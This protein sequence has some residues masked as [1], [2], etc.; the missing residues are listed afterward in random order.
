[1]PDNNHKPTPENTPAPLPSD[2]HL[3]RDWDAIRD[4]FFVPKPLTQDPLVD[5]S[6]TANNFWGPRRILTNQPKE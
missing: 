6:A 5:W 1:M 3:G 4:Y 2:L